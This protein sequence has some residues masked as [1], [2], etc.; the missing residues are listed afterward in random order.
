MKVR[1]FQN[2]IGRTARSG[3]YTSGDVIITEPNFF[4]KKD[5]HDKNYYAW[6]RCKKLINPDSSEPCG[7]SILSIFNDLFI[8]HSHYY[9]GL[10]IAKYIIDNYNSLDDVIEELHKRL[11][12][13]CNSEIQKNNLNVRISEMQFAIQ[14]IESYLCFAY[15]Q[16]NEVDI[17]ML[18]ETICKNTLAFHIVDEQKQ[19]I[20]LK[21]F[22]AIAN[23]IADLPCEKLNRY[24]TSMTGITISNKIETW[25]IENF[26]V[27]F[28]Y[29]Y[30]ELIGLVINCYRSVYDLNYSKELFKDITNMWVNGS[31]L[32]K[33]TSDTGLSFKDIEK[34]CIKTLS[35]DVS[36][37]VGN[38]LDIVN[39]QDENANFTRLSKLQKMLKYGVNSSTQIIICD[40]I[41]NDRVIS[42]II[43]SLIGPQSNFYK[44]KR[45]IKIHQKN[46]FNT[47]ND[48]PTVFNG[49]IKQ[50]ID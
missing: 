45:Q 1:N 11:I 24:A 20:L 31:S 26:N 22:K 50:L 7:S 6:E 19:P 43:T 16:S 9:N 34:I 10:D 5:N 3:M 2:L 48:Y 21:L 40:R 38:I 15:S 18:S 37:L 36:F 25:V 28:E 30:D 35:Y 14:S 12:S 33:I 41:V 47:L 8:D 46:I 23:K 39:W 27:N 4:D 42:S 13:Q 29:D 44:L 17:S 32:Y 49:K